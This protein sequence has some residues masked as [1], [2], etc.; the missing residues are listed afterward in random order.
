MSRVSFIG[1]VLVLFVT[2]C[3]AST[4]TVQPSLSAPTAIIIAEN[5]P[6]C[7]EAN[8]IYHSQLHEV[9]LTGCR[10]TSPAFVSGNGVN[11]IWGRN[12]QQWHRVTEG[13]PPLLILGGTAYDEKRNVVVL[14]GGY[15]L[16]KNKCERET[17]EWD[18]Q[19][20]VKKEA[21]SPAACDHLKMVYDASRGEVILFGGGD[22][23]TNLRTE[24]WSWNGTKWTLINHSEPPGRG[25]FGFL[26]DDTHQ[27]ILL[28]G[29]LADQVL[30]DFWTWKNGEWQKINFPGPGPLSHLGMAL[31]GNALIIFGGA[32]S[33]STLSSLSDKT[34]KLTGG[35]WSELKL[36]NHPSPRGSPAMVY[37]PEQKK[38]VLYGGVAPNRTDLNDTW[39]WDGNQWHCI[40]NCK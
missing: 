22:E 6:A 10:Q 34:W 23:N 25:H 9:L 21:E 40:V 35:A 28:Y 36:E 8:M 33:T 20:W 1:I 37:D 7:A 32:T 19:T 18:G 3:V 29:G 38:I 24:M 16:E 5:P 14:Y 39:E 17:W 15:S 11:V 2:G 4:K 27:Q 31:H 26:Y 13:G 30:D 12:G